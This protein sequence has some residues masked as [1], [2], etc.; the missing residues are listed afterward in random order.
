MTMRSSGT[1]LDTQ[2]W[3]ATPLGTSWPHSLLSDLSAGGQMSYRLLLVHHLSDGPLGD[4]LNRTVELIETSEEMDALLTSPDLAQ[5]CPTT[6]GA[7][8]TDGRWDQQPAS[9]PLRHSTGVG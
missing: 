3:A 5:W 6:I 9:H 1:R 8:A 4:G 2:T 7:A